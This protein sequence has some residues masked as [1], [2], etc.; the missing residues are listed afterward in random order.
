M[1]MPTDTVFAGD[2]PSG[3]LKNLTLRVATPED[4]ARA[5]ACFK[6]EHYLG[7]AKRSGRGLLQIVEYEGRWVALLDWGPAALKLADRDE[8]IGWTARQRADRRELVVQNRRFLVLSSERAPNLASRCLSMGLKALPGQWERAH[9]FAPLLAE[10]FTDIERFEGTCYKAANWQPVGRTK[11][12]ERHRADYYRRHDRPKKLWLY[13][14]H[15]DCAG[16]LRAPRLPE[17]YAAAVNEH[18]PERDL[19][20]KAPQ[21]RSLRQALAEVP[22]PR[23]SNSSFPI[24]SI[25]AFIAMALLAGKTSLA[26]IQRYGGF[27]THSQRV[28]LD[29]PEKKDGRG[30]RTP[31]YKALYN[32]LGKLD[33]HAFAAVLSEWLAEHEGEL[34]RALAVDGK[35]VRDQVLTLCFSEHETGAPA[36]CAIADEKPR[37]EDNKTDGELTVSKKLCSQT[38]LNG[39]VLTGDALYDKNSHIHAAVE[40]GADYLA[41]CKDERRAAHKTAEGLAAGEPPFL[42]ARPTK[43]TGVSKNGK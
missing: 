36:A 12:F 4:H 42:P 25:L 32:L 5:D 21:A 34:P 10:T 41:Q 27:L 31:S 9:G 17:P 24:G 29:F 15:R 39:A 22:D 30:R 38:N 19:P 11:G 14:L 40:A 28:W 6:S 18:S 33:P 37:T 20:L 7:A 43:A 1:N 26:A 23:A 3:L 2:P 13:P 8:W 16:L 35:Y